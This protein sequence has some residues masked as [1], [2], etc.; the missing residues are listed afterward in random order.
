MSAAKSKGR[1]ERLEE[2]RS[3]LWDIFN[4][5]WRELPRYFDAKTR[6]EMRAVG[7]RIVTLMDEHERL[8]AVLVEGSQ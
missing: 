3:E 1:D 6:G 5:D 8:D 7:K 4:N 2:I